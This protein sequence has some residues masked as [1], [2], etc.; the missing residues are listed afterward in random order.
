MDKLTGRNRHEPN[1]TL[2]AAIRSAI[3]AEQAF[4]DISIDTAT[5]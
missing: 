2:T 1:D 3:E 4:H 5:G